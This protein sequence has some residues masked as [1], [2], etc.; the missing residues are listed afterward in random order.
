MF[1]MHYELKTIVTK[2]DI[3]SSLPFDSIFL[4]LVLIR[5]IKNY[6]FDTGVRFCKVLTL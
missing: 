1:H 2:S 6:S 4:E 3:F 5:F